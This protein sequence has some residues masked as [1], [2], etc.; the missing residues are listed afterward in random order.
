[1]RKMSFFT[2]ALFFFINIIPSIFAEDSD[3]RT[4]DPGFKALDITSGLDG[5]LWACGGDASIAVSKDNG[6]RWEIREQNKDRGLFLTIRFRG[7][8]GFATGTT[9]YVAFS[10]DAG[11]TW[12][13][14]A[15]PYADV[16]SAS[17]SNATHGLLRTRAA[18]FS[19]VDGKAWS[20]VSA[21]YASDFEKFP[22][23][24]GVAALDDEHM[25]VHI[26][27]PPPSRSGFLLTKDAGTN[28]TFLE[29][30][31]VTITS[32]LVEE[33]KY[34]AVGT[35]VV[36]KDKPGGGYAVPLALYSDDG[37]HWEHT[38][39]DIQMC[40]WEGCGG[41]CTDQ[42]C[43]AASGLVMSIFQEKVDR[44][45]FPSNPELTVRW[46]ITPTA[47]CFVG[48]KLECADARPDSSADAQKMP[49][50]APTAEAQPLMKSL[51]AGTVQCIVCGLK[52]IYVDPQANGNFAL[53]TSVLINKNGLVESVEIKDA[54][55]KTPEESVRRSMMGWV[56]VPI[57]QGGVP[58][59]IKLNTTAHV[60]A[61]RPR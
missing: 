22:Y 48:A 3:W 39:H 35:E 5:T 9:G 8:F 43:L 26:S 2:C 57:E 30:P 40:H 29:I 28:W 38:E 4:S 13:H 20:S 45:V 34:W 18:V 32:L 37:E 23:V 36:H 58:V 21:K 59:N 11:A 6:A 15:V 19:T 60:M 49:G 33:D 52:S 47:I 1:M 54:P 41:R 10:Q 24:I 44:I 46:A 31:N 25:A 7:K 53:K 16:L 61:I 55:S 17:F 12:Q 50:V 42:G 27:E 14:A 51:S 56:F